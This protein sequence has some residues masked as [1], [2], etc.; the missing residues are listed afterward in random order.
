MI[1]SSLLAFLVLG[2]FAVG[3]RAE[4]PAAP[5]SEAPI[6]D[7]Q[8]AFNFKDADLSLVIAEIGKITGKTFIVDPAVKGKI[9]ILPQGSMTADEAYKAFNIALMING[10]SIVEIGNF[11]AIEPAQMIQR[12]QLPVYEKLPADLPA[13]MV[14]MIRKLKYVSAKEIYN[15]LGPILQSR[16]GEMRVFEGSNELITTDYTPNQYRIAQLLDQLDVPQ[17]SQ[18]HEPTRSKKSK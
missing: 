15:S 10:Y 9:S 12:S 6:K 4:T 11:T 7:D 5:K 14:T 13:R 3:A 17:G 18:K 8:V 16:L 2:S 1:K